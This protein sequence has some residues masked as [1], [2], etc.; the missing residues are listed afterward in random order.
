MRKKHGARGESTHVFGTGAGH[1]DPCLREERA[2]AEHEEYVEQAMYGVLA[3][4]TQ[5]LWGTEVVAEAAGG[6]APVAARVRPAAQQIHEEIT[7]EFR[8]QHLQNEIHKDA[9]DRRDHIVA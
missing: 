8:R 4:V 5:R 2:A 3:H 7:A 6:I 1:V 9:R